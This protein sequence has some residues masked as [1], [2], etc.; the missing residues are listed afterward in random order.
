LDLEICGKS[1]HVDAERVKASVESTLLYYGGWDLIPGDDKSSVLEG[2]KRLLFVN[3]DVDPWSELSVNEESGRSDV[4]TLKVFGASHH[5]WTHPVKE[6][7][8]NHVVEARQSIYRHVYD[9]LGVDAD[10]SSHYD[11][12]TE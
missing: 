6:T 10:S 8:D 7:D 4:Q 12:K 1:F 3:G 2:H 11:L 5:F 9:W